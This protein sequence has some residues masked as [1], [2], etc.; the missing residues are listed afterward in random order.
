MF[1]IINPTPSTICITGGPKIGKSTLA[2]KFG[3]TAF[4][5]AEDIGDG[6]KS[7]KTPLLK[8]YEDILNAF[9]W[10]AEAD[11]KFNACAL[12]TVDWSANAIHQKICQ[13]NGVKNIEK[14]PYGKGYMM[15]TDLWRQLI[16]CGKYLRDQRGMTMLYIA[17]T[18]IKRFEN[19]ETEA[20]DRYQLK[21]HK[22]AA[23]LIMETSDIILFANH[24]VG[25]T[26]SDAAGFKK[27]RVRAIGCG[28][29]VLYTEERPAFRAGNRFGLPPE[30]PFD[31]EGKYWD[32]IKSYIP[33][34]QQQR[35]I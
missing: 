31:T 23:D 20:Y 8:S 4:I 28:E 21:L 17:H 18:E 13:E 5:Q 26:K 29:R 10:L 34:Y 22:N 16:D 7:F 3:N 14:I 9:K 35:S 15:A 6:I 2:E 24:Y 32:I 1:S 11:H 27:D 33:Y 30:I 25:I 19:P 12:D